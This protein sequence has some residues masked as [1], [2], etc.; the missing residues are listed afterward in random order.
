M[1][2]EHFDRAS[3]RGRRCAQKLLADGIP[4]VIIADG[5]IESA[6]ALWA[7]ETGRHQSAKTILGL[8]VKIRDAR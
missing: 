3:A 4:P 2:T 1:T 8:W 7:A 5:L 6:L